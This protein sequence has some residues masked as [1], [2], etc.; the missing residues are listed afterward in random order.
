MHDEHLRLTQALMHLFARWD[1]DHQT[2]VRL[3]GLDQT[4][5]R[6]M[7]RHEMADLPYPAECMGRVQKLLRLGR[8]VETML[9][10]NP[11]AAQSWM[12]QPNRMFGGIAPLDLILKRGEEGLDALQN[13][14]DGTS[15]W[16]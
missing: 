12:L 15:A 3:L 6:M 13:H 2:Q 14:L 16:T 10:H 11:D 5:P 7:R 1:A 8:T 9:P 4:A